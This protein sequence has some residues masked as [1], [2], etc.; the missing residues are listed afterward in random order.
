[1]VRLPVYLDLSFSP[2][3]FIFSS[4][5]SCSLSPLLTRS[6]EGKQD[7]LTEKRI[8]LKA[9]LNDVIYNTDHI[10]D[11]IDN[12]KARIC[13][14]SLDRK[15][16]VELVDHIENF[17]KEKSFNRYIQ[18]IDIYFNFIGRIDFNG[19]DNLNNYI[20]EKVSKIQNKKTTGQINLH[21]NSQGTFIPCENGGGI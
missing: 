7:K 16:V 14:I 9:E 8:S 19:F 11:V 6:Y 12:F 21:K 2:I 3:E 20:K 1:M 18:R 4:P 10:S 5:F 15:T 13:I 17:R